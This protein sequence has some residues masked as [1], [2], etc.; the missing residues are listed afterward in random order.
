MKTGGFHRQLVYLQFRLFSPS[1]SLGVQE[2]HMTTVLP[3]CC[4][5]A[6]SLLLCRGLLGAGV[7]ERR[8]ILS[9]FT[10]E[11]RG[12]LRSPEAHT[13]HRVLNLS[14]CPRYLLTSILKTERHHTSKLFVVL[15]FCHHP[16]PSSVKQPSQPLSLQDYMSEC[17]SQI[18]ALA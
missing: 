18:Q 13:S 8:N 2:S 11:D 9:T 17:L 1:L 3:K 10:V 15:C 5:S 7:K 14:V 12:A 16:L 4:V 6:V